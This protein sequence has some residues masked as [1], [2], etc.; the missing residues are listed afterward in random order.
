MRFLMFAL[1]LLW[2]S[3]AIASADGNTGLIYGKVLLSGSHIP[4]CPIAVVVK[5]DRQAPQK[6]FTAGD[7]SYHFLTVSPGPVTLLIGHSRSVQALT[8]S[9]NL[10]TFVEPTYLPELRNPTMVSSRRAQFASRICP[11]NSY[12]GYVFSDFDE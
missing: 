10:L 11:E 9:A 4:V 8:V 6:T 5:S 7:G 3:T 1:A 2:S 12:H